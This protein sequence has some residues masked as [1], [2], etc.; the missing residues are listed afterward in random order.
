MA[1]FVVDSRRV[2]GV[3]HN[4]ITLPWNSWRAD[5][6]GW[7]NAHWSLSTRELASTYE[8]GAFSFIK[9]LDSRIICSVIIISIC[10]IYSSSRSH[11]SHVRHKTQRERRKNTRQ[12]LH[13]GMGTRSA[14][15]QV[16]QCNNL[17]DRHDRRRDWQTCA[18]E[19]WFV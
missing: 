10:G 11:S 1:F 2:L 16:Y 12:F 6:M 5:N 17:V 9:Y 4:I 8:R 18:R 13:G 19:L 15:Y 14:A 7:W 3:C